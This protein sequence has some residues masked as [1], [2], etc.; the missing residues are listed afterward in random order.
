MGLY[1]ITTKKKRGVTLAL[2]SSVVKDFFTTCMVENVG[3]ALWA[4]PCPL[5]Y[6]AINIALTYREIKFA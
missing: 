3:Y 1:Q 2:C 6:Q 5:T 4:I